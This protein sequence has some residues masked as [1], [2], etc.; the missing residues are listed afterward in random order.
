MKPDHALNERVLKTLGN[1]T[2]IYDYEQ[3][4]AC[5]LLISKAEHDNEDEEKTFFTQK[6]ESVFTFADFLPYDWTD[7]GVTCGLVG[8]TSANCGKE[9]WGDLQPVLKLLKKHGGPDL[10]KYA[11]TCH[12]DKDDAKKLC[13][14]IHQLEGS[15]FDAFVEAQIEALV[16]KNG[17]IYETVNAWKDVGVS[18]PSILAIA[19]VFD[20]S[21]NQGYCGKDGGCVNLKKIG[22]KHEGDENKILRDFNT[23]RRE[24]AARS[25]YNS[26]PHNGHSR[27]DMYE[28]LRKGGHFHLTVKDVKQVNSWRMK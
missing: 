7:R 21:L 28:D 19:T 20:A 23:W 1:A 27:S 25:N 13:R 6:G 17:Y 2:G 24:V 9:S 22:K 12:K 11:K 5:W 10:L 14:K 15:D 16:V 3:W 18:K 4:L 26:C 8:F